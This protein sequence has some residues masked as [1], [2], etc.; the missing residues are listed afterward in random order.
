MNKT[1]ILV[2]VILLLIIILVVMNQ[3]SEHLESPNL[4]NEAIQNIASVYANTT[5]EAI[6]N[7]IKVTRNTNIKNANIENANI[8]NFKGIINHHYSLCS[9]NILIQ[10]SF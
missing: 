6:F 1:Q 3:K 10:A 4:S 2:G 7:N 5:G 8:E 9:R